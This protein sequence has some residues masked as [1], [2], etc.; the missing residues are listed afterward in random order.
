MGNLGS[1][2]T[3]NLLEFT[4]I[5][6][7]GV[8]TRPF[9][10][11]A[12]MTLEEMYESMALEEMLLCPDFPTELIVKKMAEQ[13]EGEEDL[14]PEA[15]CSNQAPLEKEPSLPQDQPQAPDHDQPSSIQYNNFI[16]SDYQSLPKMD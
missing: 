2:L 14:L 1:Q 16:D 13:A 15:L 3:R 4:L 11:Y 7:N 12:N 5:D 8:V 9:E 6:D 10:K